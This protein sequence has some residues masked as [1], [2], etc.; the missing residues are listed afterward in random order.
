M[1]SEKALVFSRFFVIAALSVAVLFF[2]GNCR[3][4][5]T[6]S[7]NRIVSLSPSLTQMAFALGLGERLVGVTKYDEKP[8]SVKKLPRVGGFLDV[9]V[10]AVAR[11]EP[12]LVLVSE[13]HEPV[14]DR[15]HALGIDALELRTRSIAE[16]MDSIR[17]LGER[18]GTS[19]QADAVVRR[20][21]EQLAPETCAA[22][23]LRVLVTLGRSPGGLEHLV[24]AGPGTYLD[25]LVR[26]C[27]ARNA[28][29]DGPAAYPAMGMERLVEAAP[30]VIV[31]LSPDGRE[32]PWRRVPFSRWPRILTIAD[33]DFSTPG[34][35][36]GRVKR[37]LCRLLCRPEP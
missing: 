34:V 1:N 25:E 3:R 8:E 36:L 22:G 27:G 6:S 2:A 13:L 37:E 18:T 9:D 17:R 16:V 33:P 32:G 30:D 15:L 7:S 26:L 5:P 35:E 29:P 10:E 12:D 20:L 28:L 31:D 19:G 24:A 23:S 4:T 21:R 14:A 11:L